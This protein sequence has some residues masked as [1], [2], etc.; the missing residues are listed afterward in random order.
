MDP[1][2][3][4]GMGARYAEQR[5]RSASEKEVWTF[6]LVYA[7]LLHVLFNRHLEYYRAWISVVVIILVE[8]SW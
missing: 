4:L 8:T 1:F 7:K 5:R 6:L 3:E 2:E